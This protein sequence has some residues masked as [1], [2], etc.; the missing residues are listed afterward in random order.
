MF[1][2][3]DPPSERA[4]ESGAGPLRRAASAT[5]IVSDTATDGSLASSAGTGSIAGVHE[6]WSESDGEVAVDLEDVV[7]EESLLRPAEM[8]AGEDVERPP[9]PRARDD[10][11]LA[12]VD[13]RAGVVDGE[14]VC[15]QDVVVSVVV[16]V[17]PW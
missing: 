4:D 9:V 13:D 12:F 7:R 11:V 16:R 14:F 15:R 10:H 8:V 5:R 2:C 1:S 3:P 6:R 17:G